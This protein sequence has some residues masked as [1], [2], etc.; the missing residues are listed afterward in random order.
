MVEDLVMKRRA[1]ERH[2]IEQAQKGKQP[3]P[4]FYDYQRELIS[5]LRKDF[6]P[7]WM[8]KRL[9]QDIIPT[10]SHESDG[11]IF[12]VFGSKVPTC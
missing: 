4:V 12:Q 11:L 10:L 2:S 8:A 3:Y 7:L 9:L 6:W 1:T 5:V